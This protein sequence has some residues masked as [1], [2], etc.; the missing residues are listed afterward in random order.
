MRPH[1]S[2]IARYLAVVLAV[3][4]AVGGLLLWKRSHALD[5]GSLV[6][7]T[8]YYQQDPSRFDSLFLGDSRTFCDL[9][10]ERLDPLL[11]TRSYNL[12]TWTNWFPTQYAQF[13][14]LVAHIP[15]GTVVVW[16]IGYLNFVDA[17][18][19][20]AY[21]IGWQRIPTMR[22]FGFEIG[23]LAENLAE[24]T[25][26]SNVF[27]LRSAL[28]SLLETRLQTPLITLGQPRDARMAASE[29]PGEAVHRS[30]S[31]DP[32]TGSLEIYHDDGDIVSIA[33]SLRNGAYSRHEVRP[34]FYRQRQKRNAVA[35]R[36]PSPRLRALFAAILDLFHS[37]GVKL[38]VNVLGEAPYVHDGPAREAQAAFLNGPI[39]REVE[40]R[41]YPL[42]SAALETLTD[43]DYFDYN[44]LNIVGVGRYSA[45]L[46]PVLSEAI[47]RARQS[48]HGL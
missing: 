22:R 33:A 43:A 31:R 27:T 34:E 10:P 35:D 42:I 41:G 17:A 11:G 8:A 19:R 46:A 36:P 25:P 9:H 37:H 26:G 15:R 1:I 44:H 28:I 40:A 20:P 23:E 16:S 48:D 32:L 3:F 24:W 12:A 2:L 4:M 29:S 13:S 45:L 14:D 21:P 30:L 18:I 5:H 47:Q 7:K 6:Q 38:I 39:R